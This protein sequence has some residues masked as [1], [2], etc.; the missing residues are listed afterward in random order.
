MQTSY[1][2][3]ASYI[4]GKSKA[5]LCKSMRE[6]LLR[7]PVFKESNLR[8][9]N[10]LLDENFIT[11][12]DIDMILCEIEEDRLI[13]DYIKQLKISKDDMQHHLSN[14][15]DKISR[16]P[17]TGA[18][19]MDGNE[20]VKFTAADLE[21]VRE[22]RPAIRKFVEDFKEEILMWVSYNQKVVEKFIE[23]LIALSEKIRSERAN[24]E[25]C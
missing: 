18:G 11:L 6:C 19:V 8:C 4:E 3:N 10:L 12:K 7:E 17:L 20:E 1:N 24:I 25:K 14:T 5:S 2:Y 23:D 22:L 16:N 13:Y 21:L 9:L 15:M